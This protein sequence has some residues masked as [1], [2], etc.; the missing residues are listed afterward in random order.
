[1]NESHVTWEA[2]LQETAAAFSYPPTPDIAAGVRQR[3]ARSV[4]RRQPRAWAY[5]LLLLLA[6]LAG[7]LAVPQVRAAFLQLF[8]AG[9]ITISVTEPTPTAANDALLP[10]TL[11][12]LATAVAD[13]A[14]RTTLT[15][16]QAQTPFSL[17]LPPA[18]GAPDD[19]FLQQISDP[20]IAGAIVI[21]VWRAPTPLQLHQIGADSY[22]LKGASVDAVAQT[23][24]NGRTAFW[25]EGGHRI[26]LGDGQSYTVAENVLIWTEGDV[27]YRLQS[28]LTLE[29]A[30]Q[31]A[32]S[33]EPMEE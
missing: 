7:L 15:K 16:A 4:R 32:A 30:V 19:V 26:L 31:I 24:V 2:T 3:L 1:M 27:T 25:I 12:S 20:G 14:G 17:R 9:A 21:M 6:L 18:Y 22:G 5:A 8:R 10:P 33:L 11:P 13:F 23:M 28:M 29:E